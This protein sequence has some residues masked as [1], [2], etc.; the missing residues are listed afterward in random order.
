MCPAGTK[1]PM[2]EYI[3]QLQAVNT[4]YINKG[5]NVAIKLLSLKLCSCS[6]INL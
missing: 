1:P 5:L 4:V 2:L 3:G 6:P